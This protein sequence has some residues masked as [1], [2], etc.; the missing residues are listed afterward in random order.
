MFVGIHTIVRTMMMIIIVVVLVMD[1]GGE[2][3]SD[4]FVRLWMWIH[5]AE[6]ER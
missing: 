4:G 3:E 6:Y 2:S 1:G 5:R